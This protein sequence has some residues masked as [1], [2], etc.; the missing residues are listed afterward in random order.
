MQREP[1]EILFST[2]KK[3]ASHRPSNFFYLLLFLV[4]LSAVL[5]GLSLYQPTKDAMEDEPDGFKYLAI[6]CN[7]IINTFVTFKISKDNL[8]HFVENC[9]GDQQE[10][11]KDQESTNQKFKLIDYCKSFFSIPISV[12][13]GVV[14]SY[15]SAWSP[16]LP[17]WTMFSVQLLNQFNINYYS[18]RPRVSKFLDFLILSK[19]QKQINSHLDTFVTYIDQINEKIDSFL[20]YEHKDNNV[21][22]RLLQAWKTEQWNDFKEIYRSYLNATPSTINIFKKIFYYFFQ[23]INQYSLIIY[24]NSTFDFFNSFE[25]LHDSISWLLTGFCLILFHMVTWDFSADAF[26]RTEDVLNSIIKDYKI[27]FRYSLKNSTSGKVMLSC[28]IF[29]A[30]LGFFYSKNLLDF[31][32]FGYGNVKPNMPFLQGNF[33]YYFTLFAVTLDSIVYNLMGAV[34]PCAD[35]SRYTLLL[36]G[37]DKMQLL[38]TLKNV[39]LSCGQYST[40]QNM[41]LARAVLGIEAGVDSLLNSPVSTFGG[42]SIYLNYASNEA[43]KDNNE[44]RVKCN[45]Y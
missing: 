34:E 24:Y 44:M 37:D 9:C 8:N 25:N 5:G 19:K 21:A 16:F 15:I 14:I 29:S 6:L 36:K 7:I 20:A 35:F 26:G 27:S 45:G 33:A 22:N 12:S 3:K 30:L 4:S 13:S 31:A 43:K 23:L 18:A 39:R 40:G 2:A 42:S 28:L 41:E 1:I 11:F 10:E 17:F 32:A 38:E